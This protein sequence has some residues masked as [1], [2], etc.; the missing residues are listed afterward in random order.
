MARKRTEGFDAEAYRHW[1]NRAEF[2][3]LQRVARYHRRVIEREDPECERAIQALE[4]GWLSER[5]EGGP[6]R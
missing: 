6:Q 1:Q 4:A 5:R 2:D 3:E